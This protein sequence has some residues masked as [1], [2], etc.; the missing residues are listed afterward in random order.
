MKFTIEKGIP[1]PPTHK[2]GDSL[3]ATL[4]AM[5]VGDSFEHPG[6]KNSGSIFGTASRLKPKKFS[7]RKQENGRI[8]VWRVE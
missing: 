1:I 7:I 2:S 4:Q 5:E 6:V 3:R 8:R